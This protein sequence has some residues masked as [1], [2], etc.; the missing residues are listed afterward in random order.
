MTKS[1]QAGGIIDNVCYYWGVERF[2]NLFQL[3]MNVC[4]N[5]ALVNVISLIT[6]EG[7]DS[8][9]ATKHSSLLVCNNII[10][11]PHTVQTTLVKC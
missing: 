5:S 10:M 8:N 7:Q 6:I 1:C 2:K 9:T 4:T 3:F 11:S